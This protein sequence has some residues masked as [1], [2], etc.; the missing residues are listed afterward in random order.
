MKELDFTM[1]GRSAERVAKLLA[2]RNDVAVPKVYWRWTTEKVLIMDYIEGVNWL[3]IFPP[4]SYRN[5]EMAS[6]LTLSSV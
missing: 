6:K 2:W 5:T 3:H 4:D 1:E